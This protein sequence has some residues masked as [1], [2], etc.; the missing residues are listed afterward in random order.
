MTTTNLKPKPDSG[1]CI[2]CDL[3]SDCNLVHG[4]DGPVWFCEEYLSTPLG[5]RPEQESPINPGD[6]DGP[7]P[8]PTVLGLCCNCEN[9]PDCRLPKPEAGVW[10][11]EEYA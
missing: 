1:L 6:L 4:G 8:P 11:C 10:F 7:A 2:T 3:V 9:R 5:N